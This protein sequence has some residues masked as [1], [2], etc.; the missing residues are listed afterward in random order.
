MAWQPPEDYQPIRGVSAVILT[1]S[2]KVGTAMFKLVS[3]VTNHQ[4]PTDVHLSQKHARKL[5]DERM[6]PT[7]LYPSVLAVAMGY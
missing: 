6:V 5:I 3:M 4:T 7:G 2:P 1:M